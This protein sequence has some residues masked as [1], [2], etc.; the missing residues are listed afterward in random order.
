MLVLSRK[1][2]ERIYVIVPPSD[3]PTV[4]ALLPV[5]IRGDKVRLGLEAAE[6]VSIKR[7]ELTESKWVDLLAQQLAATSD[8]LDDESLSPLP[9]EERRAG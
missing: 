9:H 6:R 8:V 3:E 2:L 7:E 1:E 5:D 4:V